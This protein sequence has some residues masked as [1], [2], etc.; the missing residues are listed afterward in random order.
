MLNQFV[1]HINEMYEPGHYS[2]VIQ[3][4][5]RENPHYAFYLDLG[6]QAV[7]LKQGVYRGQPAAKV[8]LTQHSLQMLVGNARSFDF[9]NASTKQSIS[10]EGD[11]EIVFYLGELCKRMGSTDLQRW[12]DSIRIN[13]ENGIGQVLYLDAPDEQTVVENIRRRQP[14]VIRNKLARWQKVR[15]PQDLVAHYG[16]TVVKYDPQGRPITVRQF[17]SDMFAAPADKRVHTSGARLPEVI[18]NDIPPPYFQPNDYIAPQ[19]WMGNSLEKQCCTALHRDSHHGFL[20]H[21]YGHKHFKIFKPS[22]TQYLY[23]M[24]GQMTAQPSWVDISAPNLDR[25]PQFDRATPIDL[26]L[27]AGDLLVLPAGWYHSVFALDPVMSISR[28]LRGDV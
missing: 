21:L 22:D 3:C 23:P 6:D 18:W 5:L 27:E 14:M 12:Q 28:F 24:K 25:Y 16:D 13:Q 9:R 11:S 2:G 26:H 7:A 8:T 17:V 20:A 10:V 15:S 19:I 4:A 1:N